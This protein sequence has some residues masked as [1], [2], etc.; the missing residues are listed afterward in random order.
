MAEMN[1]MML[2]KS[3]NAFCSKPEHKWPIVHHTDLK[4]EPL[5]YKYP[6]FR[7]KSGTWEQKVKVI[8]KPCHSSKNN[9]KASRNVVPMQREHT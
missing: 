2:I 7:K 3:N 9:N 1:I 8:S 6:S 5:I 4:N